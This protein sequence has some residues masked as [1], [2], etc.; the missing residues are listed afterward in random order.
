MSDKIGVTKLN[1][2]L[3]NNIPKIWSKQAYVQGFDGE[4]IYFKNDVNMFERMEIAKS[5]YEGVVTPYY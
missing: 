3:S 1:E 5:I 4:T 2:I